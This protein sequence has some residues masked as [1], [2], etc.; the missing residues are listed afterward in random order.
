MKKILD[1][2]SQIDAIDDKLLLLLARRAR[3]AIRVGLVKQHHGLAARSSDRERQILHRLGRTNEGP[4]DAAA[5]KRI[6]HLIV[7]ES[8]R[9]A[10]R[11]RYDHE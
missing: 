8:R 1:L 7:Q 10:I 9:A 6:F 4:L 3:L 2:R 11:V 5:I